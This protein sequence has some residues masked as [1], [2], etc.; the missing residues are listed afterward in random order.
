MSDRAFFDTNI[1]LCSKDARDQRKQSIADEL[2]ARGIGEGTLVVSA[3]VLNEFYV[4]ATQKLTPGIGREDARTV[5]RSR[6]RSQHDAH[7]S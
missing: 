6:A 4:T 5:C 1:I 2:I 7:G 3:Q